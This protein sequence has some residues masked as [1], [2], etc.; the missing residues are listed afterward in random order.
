MWLHQKRILFYLHN[1]NKFDAMNFNMKVY[2]VDIK[3][4][5]FSIYHRW[6]EIIRITFPRDICYALVIT[7]MKHLEYIRRQ[8]AISRPKISCA[9][10]NYFRPEIYGKEK[11]CVV[12]SRRDHESFSGVPFH[13]NCVVPWIV[14]VF[15][16]RWLLL[17][18]IGQLDVRP[19]VAPPEKGHAPLCKYIENIYSPILC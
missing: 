17:R 9:K 11:W 6:E 4:Q 8:A 10:Q 7:W 3:I 16:Q 5:H 19:E 12:C 13:G 15:C 1:I 18:L 2:R 14:S